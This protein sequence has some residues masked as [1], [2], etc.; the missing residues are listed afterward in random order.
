MA[1]NGRFL[2]SQ[3][4][5][6]V[7]E[8]GCRLLIAPATS[9]YVLAK[10]V[11]LRFGW[12]PRITSAGD[13]YRS[14]EIQERIFKQRYQ[15]SYIQYAAGKVDRRVWNGVAYYRKPGTAAA[16]VPGTSNHG[17]GIAV[18]V[19]HMSYNTTRWNQFA[20]V[21]T[22]LG[23][24]NREGR[25]VNEA[26][27]WVYARDTTIPVNNPFN[28][29][30]SVDVPEIEGEIGKLTPLEED[31]DMSVL[32]RHP[33]GSVAL[34]SSDGTFEV[35]ANIDELN[36]L[37]ALDLVKIN[38]DEKLGPAGTYQLA[39]GLIWDKLAAIAWRKA[40]RSSSDP[41]AVAASLAPLLI[42][43]IVSNLQIGTGVSAESLRSVVEDSVRD[44]LGGL[45]D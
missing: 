6:V 36:A 15:P 7:G 32:V 29:P 2:A 43:A 30:T 14:Y 22:S 10:T 9:W 39:D 18:D 4:A 45:N 3:L 23:W 25:A 20:L 34:A 41:R 33:N 37:K 13:A 26:W 24:S 35:L 12:T 44:V 42:P 21:A 1:L 28:I 5:Y 27:H 38:K 16:A 8:P 40:A 11:Q 19:A 17:L 31:P